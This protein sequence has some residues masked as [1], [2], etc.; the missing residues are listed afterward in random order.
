M[1]PRAVIPIAVIASLCAA[2]SA[3]SS[4][5]TP[6][7]AASGAE[8]TA[9]S[10]ASP[11]PTAASVVA[12]DLTCSDF[13]FAAPRLATQIKHVGG[14]VGFPETGSDVQVNLD[15]AK[16]EMDVLVAKAPECAP[17]AVKALAAL[18]T[19]TDALL[20]TFKTGDDP[21]IVAADKAALNDVRA[22]GIAA[23]KVMKINPVGWEGIFPNAQ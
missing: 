5:Q 11:S 8:S 12:G 14:F 15:Q 18:A 19:S 20:V 22:K 10:P 17:K 1:R 13:D 4:S 3:T 21:E 7:A 9:S 23:W 2:C 16:Y 6:T